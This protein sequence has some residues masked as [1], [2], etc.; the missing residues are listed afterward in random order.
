M[1]GSLGSFLGV[2]PF[3]GPG[4][5]DSLGMGGSSFPDNSHVS[6]VHPGLSGTQHRFAGSSVLLSGS[7]VVSSSSSLSHDGFLESGVPCLDP[8]GLSGVPVLS[9][10]VGDGFVV[11][12]GNIGKVL[13]D[14][15]GS[16]GNGIL[17][18]SLTVEEG[19]VT[20]VT[21]GGDGSESADGSDFAE[22][23]D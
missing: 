14:P 9:F 13:F 21:G 3:G 6:S 10:E 1:V 5:D 18:G 20:E 22:H 23:I 12:G 7:S 8:S 15:L 2:S 16:L 17:E 4:F 11:T 19:E